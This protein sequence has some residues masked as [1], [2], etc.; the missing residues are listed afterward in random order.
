MLI[1]TIFQN[2]IRLILPGFYSVLFY[3][4]V[5]SHTLDHHILSSLILLH[6]ITIYYEEN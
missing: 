6:R 4:K 3:D 2:K 5:L 1:F